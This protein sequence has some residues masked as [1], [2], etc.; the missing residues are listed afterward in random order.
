M[1]HLRL[2]DLI[3]AFV[4]HLFGGT[5]EEGMQVFPGLWRNAHWQWCDAVCVV[6]CM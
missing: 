4:V 3:H 6:V 5:G 1:T 2:N